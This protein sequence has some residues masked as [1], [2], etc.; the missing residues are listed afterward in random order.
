MENVFL[1]AGAG[2]PEVLLNFEIGV[3]SFRG[4]S[5]PED[6]NAFYGSI[7]QSVSGYLSSL[8]NGS[9]KVVMHLLYFNSAS[10]KVFYNLFQTIEDFINKSGLLAEVDWL[11]HEEDDMSLEFANGFIEDFEQIKFNLIT[12]D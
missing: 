2:T 5:Y 12:L 10:T 4:E 3:F 6:V 11:Y 9:I 8:E 7:M 1:P